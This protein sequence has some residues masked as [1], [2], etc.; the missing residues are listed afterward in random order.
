MEDYFCVMHRCMET[1]VAK[2]G[3][4]HEDSDCSS[5]GCG[6]DSRIPDNSPWLVNVYCESGTTSR[7]QTDPANTALNNHL[8]HFVY[9][10]RFV[11]HYTVI[12]TAPANIVRK[13]NYN[14]V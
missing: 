4:C 1:K 12:L 10:T 14:C 3:Q 6:R 7:H 9:L 13:T 5:G 2:G 8:M 11:L